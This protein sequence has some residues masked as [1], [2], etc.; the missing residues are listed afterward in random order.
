MNDWEMAKKNGG[1]REEEGHR[2]SLQH[3]VFREEEAP[4]YSDPV[5]NRYKVRQHQGGGGCC[6][7]GQVF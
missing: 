2:R 1:A 7:V 6:R 3:R 4:V 5:L